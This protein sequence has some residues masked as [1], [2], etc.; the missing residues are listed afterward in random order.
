MA[1]KG[2]TFKKYSPDFKLSVI[3]DM[4]NNHLSYAET[5]RKYW[6]TTTKKETASAVS[7]FMPNS[8]GFGYHSR[9]SQV[10]ISL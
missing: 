9:R 5:I 4:R 2:Q 3:L 6:L 1:K 8:Q 10:I 7:F